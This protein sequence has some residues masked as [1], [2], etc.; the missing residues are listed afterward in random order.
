GGTINIASPTSSI[1]MNTNTSGTARA[2]IIRS[3]IGGTDITV[4]ANAVAGSVNSFMVLGASPS[5]TTNTFTGDL[6]F[7]GTFPTGATGFSQ[8]AIDSPTALPST[9]T[10][11]MKRTL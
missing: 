9:A 4:V 6:I 8:I 1:V 5:G 11:R 10:V 2:Q 7:G 3:A